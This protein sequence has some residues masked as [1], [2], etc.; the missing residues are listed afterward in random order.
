MEQEPAVK[1]LQHVMLVTAAIVNN[2]EHAVTS[3]IS[4]SARGK[5]VRTHDDC[6]HMMADH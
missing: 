6:I 3:G 5:P 4:Y 2:R 1:V